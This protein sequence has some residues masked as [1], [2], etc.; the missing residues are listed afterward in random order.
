MK[1]NGESEAA[2]DTEVPVKSEKHTVYDEENEAENQS[3]DK[4][5]EYSDNDEKDEQAGDLEDKTN[6]D[7]GGKT[8]K[9][10]GYDEKPQS[11]SRGIETSDDEEEKEEEIEENELP[12]ITVNAFGG[13]PQNRETGN[14]ALK[15]PLPSSREMRVQPSDQDVISVCSLG[16]EE[17]LDEDNLEEG[18]ATNKGIGLFN[19]SFA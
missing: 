13:S 17:E 19:E 3:G 10:S 14:I 16:E 18:D 15:S 7:E 2:I 1:G 6:N 9:L 12:A 5:G 11:A 4:E 8:G